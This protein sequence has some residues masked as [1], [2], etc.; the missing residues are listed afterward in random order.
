MSKNITVHRPQNKYLTEL[1]GDD[2]DF[3]TILCTL[4]SGGFVPIHSHA[5]RETFYIISGEIEGLNV[6]R[7]QTLRAGDVFDVRDGL[8]HAWRNLSGKEAVMLCVTTNRIG[9]FLQEVSR[10]AGDA[11]VV[12][13]FIRLCDEHGYWLGSPDD[14]AAVGLSV[15]ISQLISTSLPNA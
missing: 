3:C 9:R 12:Q 11:E 13:R 10:P 15:P 1:T 2:D 6:S 5:D 8:K 4:P 7:W 14:N